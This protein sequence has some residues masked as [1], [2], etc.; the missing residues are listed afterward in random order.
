VPPLVR[1]PVVS[2]AT[3]PGANVKRR[4]VCF[5]CRLSLLYSQTVIERGPAVT[6]FTAKRNDRPC[7]GGHAAL[8]GLTVGAGIVSADPPF[9]VPDWR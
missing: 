1:G 9:H 4:V 6:R 8:L 5:P 3:V 7:V 2:A